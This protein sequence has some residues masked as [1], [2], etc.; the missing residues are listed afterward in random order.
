MNNSQLGEIFAKLGTSLEGEAGYWTFEFEGVF[1]VC[2]T[3]EQAD[4]MRIMTPI[5]SLDQVTSE[6]MTECMAAN[7][8]RALDARY[9]ADAEN[10]WGAFIHPLSE[11]S[12]KLVFSALHQ[13]A[14]VRN[15]FGTSYS[16]GI[17]QFGGGQTEGLDS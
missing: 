15:S 3:D 11:L 12:G 14:G 13:V 1:M 2:V 17:F 7:F 5:A 16:S 6:Q 4:R 8:D 10:L 9:C